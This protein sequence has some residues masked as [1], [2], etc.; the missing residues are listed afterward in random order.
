MLTFLWISKNVYEKLGRQ[1]F[2]NRRLRFSRL[3]L[4]TPSVRPVLFWA[5]RVTSTRLGRPKRNR[6]TT[7]IFANGR[8]LLNYNQQA[9]RVKGISVHFH[10]LL[11]TARTVVRSRRAYTTGSS[12][13][14]S[15]KGSEYYSARD[16]SSS[17]HVI[18][19][20]TVAPC[21]CICAS[22]SRISF[23]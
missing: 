6:T 13:S 22:R 12:S 4:D 17:R 23:V 8:S 1:A 16:S 20:I 14:L 5:L 3:A 7:G 9:E 15:P 10:G 11:I 2:W 18:T 19:F 21:W